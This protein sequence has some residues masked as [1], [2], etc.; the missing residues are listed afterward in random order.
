MAQNQKTIERT[1]IVNIEIF[2]WEGES[3]RNLT[4][5]DVEQ[6]TFSETL[7]NMSAPFTIAMHISRLDNNDKPLY[8]TMEPHDVVIFKTSKNNNWY[9][10]YIGLVQSINTNT[11]VSG[12]AHE[13]SLKTQFVIAGVAITSIFDLSFDFTNNRLGAT[14]TVLFYDVQQKAAE[15][16]VELQEGTPVKK[17]I[18]K[19][20]DIWFGILAG[21][22]GRNTS[23]FIQLRMYKLFKQYIKI[24]AGDDIKHIM[25]KYFNPPQG[26]ITLRGLL[27]QMAN[28]PWI[29]LFVR[30]N[31]QQNKYEITLLNKPLAPDS[32]KNLPIN[33]LK[34]DYL[35]SLN[36]HRTMNDAITATSVFF[37]E[38][39]AGTYLRQKADFLGKTNKNNSP[40][41]INEKLVEKFGYRLYEAEIRHYDYNKDGELEDLAKQAGDDLSK[42]FQHAHD[43][44]SGNIIIAE[45]FEF[46]PIGQKL[47]IDGMEGHFFIERVSHHGGYGIPPSAQIDVTRGAIYKNGAFVRRLHPK[48]ESLTSKP[49]TTGRSE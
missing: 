37:P 19:F 14:Q 33:T 28:H 48:I 2:S 41:K 22:S 35:K 34:L 43:Y 29:F 44:Y 10:R 23:E 12:T 39:I 46:Y 18:T 13:A 31:P 9:I 15:I 25:P 47:Q 36:L 20:I 16:S 32:W 26:L 40:H 30:M 21:M 49:F 45:D 27:Q 7:D 11:S 24:S 4:S 38:S 5:L 3:R 1:P 8:E 6:Y 17:T 42:M